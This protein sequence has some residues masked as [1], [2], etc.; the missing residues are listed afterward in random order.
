M[1]QPPHQDP[2]SLNTEDQLLITNRVDLVGSSFVGGAGTDMLRL[3]G[4]GA[5]GVNS[6]FAM[7]S[8]EIISGSE[9]NDT[10]I[11]ETR[12]IDQF[13]TIDG[14]GGQDVLWLNGQDP[15][16]L[17]GKT[18][19]NFDAISLI[20]DYGTTV[21]LSDK[22]TA[23]LMHGVVSNDDVLILEGETFTEEERQQLHRQ[24][25]D[26]ITDQD[27]TYEDLP[28]QVEGL[29]G[30]LRLTAGETAFLNGGQDTVVS[31]E[32]PSFRSLRILMDD[33]I[34]WDAFDVI[35]LDTSGSL[36]LSDGLEA[37]STLSVA[38]VEVG[39]ITS[40]SAFGF[41]IT[42]NDEASASRVEEILN[43]LR[44]SHA[45]SDTSYVG[46]RHFDIQLQD[47]GYRT[48]YDRID[49]AI[50]PDDVFVL[51]FDT[52][53]LTGTGSD[54]TFVTHFLALSAF[55]Q[56]DGGDGT[57]TLMLVGN[58]GPMD[59]TFL[60][61]FGSVEIVKG[62]TE[63]DHIYIGAA[64]LPDIQTIDGGGGFN[65]AGMGDVLQLTGDGTFDL[66][67]K[68]IISFDHIEFSGDQATVLVSDKDVAFQLRGN[69]DK[70]TGNSENVVLEN[71]LF[72]AEERASLHGLGINSIT[73]E[74][75]TYVDRPAILASLDADHV[76]VLPGGTAFID[77][78]RNAGLTDDSPFIRRLTV[79]PP[80]ESRGDGR[81]R[82][83]HIG[84]GP[85]LAGDRLA[86]RDLGRRRDDRP[87]RQRVP[88]EPRHR[89][90]P[91]GRAFSRAGGAAGPDRHER[92][93][94]GD[95]CRN[96]R[97]DHPDRG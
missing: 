65:G 51:S 25:I 54:D 41:D 9:K 97:R 95:A 58:N 2:Q 26:R 90:Q 68:S 53:E 45:A 57:D 3:V 93:R 46:Y 72:T 85:A 14:G 59:L 5:F 67:G 55:D 12:F 92:K 10:L 83:R 89:L 27:G 80:A 4:G 76:Q 79:T 81:V 78:G 50:G 1:D 28:P 6:A 61:E 13:V 19:A 37:G 30:T 63:A 52:D 74:S 60:E 7:S 96:S 20:A 34:G 32:A 21:T 84:I 86:Q 69:A 24:G 88:G 49:L 66:R 22:A 91:R 17:V 73:D 8:I 31:D 23:L 44:Y 71:G 40:P 64:Q 77:G 39:T 47:E 70:P 43:G 36:A 38:G 42:F 33:Y 11:L 56:I 16:N 87:D 15:F 48:S 18:I 94:G 62:T 35:D 75:G 82:H 29:T